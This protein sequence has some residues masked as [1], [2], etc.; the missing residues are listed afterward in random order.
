MK[1]KLLGKTFLVL[2]EIAAST[3]PLS[4]KLLSARLKMHPSTLSRITGDLVEAAYLRKTSYRDFEPALGLIYLGQRATL[5]CY[6]PKKVNKLVRAHCQGTKIKGALAGVFKGCLVYLYI[7]DSDHADRA[8]MPF[9]NQPHTSNIALTVL[10]VR[11]GK[12]EAL[13]ILRESLLR[14]VPKLPLRDNLRFYS[15]RLDALAEKGYSLWDGKSYWNVCHPISWQGDIFGLSLFCG[16][17][18]QL[19]KEQLVRESSRL[20]ERIREFLLNKTPA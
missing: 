6:F 14:N 2:E 10:G 17:D 4:L 7:S 1:N 3:S 20:A 8:G 19:S 9:V 12:K 18:G 11:H 5:N 16:S 15:E 13:K